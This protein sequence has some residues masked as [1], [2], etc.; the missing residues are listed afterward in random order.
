MNVETSR[1]VHVVRRWGKTLPMRSN[2]ANPALMRTLAAYLVSRLIGTPMIVPLNTILPSTTPC[3]AFTA[4]ILG[5][6]FVQRA[7]RINRLP[8]KH[9]S[10]ETDFVHAAEPQKIASQQVIFTGVKPGQLG[11]RLANDDSR[12]QGKTGHMAG[13]PKLLVGDIQI[14]HHAVVL[15]I[16]VHDGGQMLHLIAL[17]IDAAYGIDIEYRLAEVDLVQI[18]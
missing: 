12:H 13:H 6:N 2:P 1:P 5:R 18:I 16:N 11:G 7:I 3:T 15:T 4:R 8:G 14:S 10:T 9:R 17:G